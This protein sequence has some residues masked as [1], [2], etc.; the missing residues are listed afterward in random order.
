M[1]TYLPHE[2]PEPLRK[3][4]EQELINLRGGGVGERKEWERIYDYATYND[5]GCEDFRAE[6]ARP[7]LGG[8]TQYPYPR[9]GRTGRPPLR[10]GQ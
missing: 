5:L 8:S 2:T 1:Q 9:R 3:Y 10:S 7:T 6:Y 4:R